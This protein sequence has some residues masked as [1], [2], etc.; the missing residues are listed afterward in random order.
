M[1]NILYSIYVPLSYILAE[2][3]GSG[4]GVDFEGLVRIVGEIDFVE[5]L[6]GLVLNRF[7]LHLMRRILSLA[8]E[9]GKR[10]DERN[11]R[12]CSRLPCPQRLENQ[13]NPDESSQAI[14]PKI[15]PSTA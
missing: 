15:E 10:G 13:E 7:H 3:L 8:W 4:G 2:V 9:R 6:S 14:D 1:P 11:S 5:Y 12:Y